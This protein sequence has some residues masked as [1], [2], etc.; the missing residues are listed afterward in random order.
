M[1]FGSV[2]PSFEAWKLSIA[3]A[4][5]HYLTVGYE[6]LAKVVYRCIPRDIYCGQYII[7]RDCC[8]SL[9]VCP[10]LLEVIIGNQVR[11]S[12]SKTQICAYHY[13]RPPSAPKTRER[14][15]CWFVLFVRLYSTFDTIELCLESGK[16]VRNVHWHVSSGWR[17]FAMSR[18]QSSASL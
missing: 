6:S 7:L 18:E 16:F 9:V 3:T 14:R 11:L 8:L 15:L 2:R 5:V 13:K 12:R 4:E 1:S 17:G 10:C